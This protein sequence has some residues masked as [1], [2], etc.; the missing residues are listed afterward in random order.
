MTVTYTTAAI[1]KEMVHHVSSDLANEDIEEMINQVESEVDG[2]MKKSGINKSAGEAANDFTFS[3][4]KHGLIRMAVSAR[5]AL[6]VMA[7]DTEEYTSTSHAALTA[8]LMFAIWLDCKEQLSDA[9]V[10]DYLVGL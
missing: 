4:T 10:I 6:M 5:V 3:A 2:I 7:S 1:V 8:D 9:R